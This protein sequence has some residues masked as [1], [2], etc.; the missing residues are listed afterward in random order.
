MNSVMKKML[1]L[2]SALIAAS[3]CAAKWNGANETLT[4]AEEH[5]ISVDSQT[6]TMTIALEGAAADLSDLDKARLR[7]FAT[8]YSRDGHG[9]LTITT[10][11]G[12]GAA[13]QDVAANVRKE[14]YNAGVSQDALAG[15]TYRQS[16]GGASDLILSYTRYVATPSACGIWEGGR[17]RDYRNMRSPNFGCATQNN[18]AAMIGD[19]R[20]LVEPAAMTDPDAEFRIRGVELFRQG[21]TTSSETDGEIE[22]RVSE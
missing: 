20:D 7:A 2:S 1:L 11:A 4:V 8:A 22:Q 16:E 13:S 9:G 19:P 21:Q 12:A 5:P 6:V 3:G 18:L 10:P 14:L 15:S 17:E